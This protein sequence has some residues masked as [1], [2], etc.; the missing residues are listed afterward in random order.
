MFIIQIKKG[1]RIM[2]SPY[3]TLFAF[4]ALL[5]L[6][7]LACY[8][9]GTPP[10]ATQAPA[11]EPPTV[12][13]PQ[14]TDASQSTEPPAATETP[15]QSNAK[16]FF[17]E[18][19]DGDISNWTYFT[20]KNDPKADDSGVKPVTDNSFLV[21]DLTKNLN[22][23]VMYDP[24]TYTNVRLDVRVENRGT[25]N[26][27]INLVCRY[28]KEGWYE[29]AIANNGLYWLL[30]YDGVKGT[31]AQLANGGSNKI[32]AG[33]EVNEYTFICND[34]NLIVKIN[35][36]D[37]TTYTD[38]QY[39]FREGQIG[40]GASSFKDIPVKVEYDWVKISEP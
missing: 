6:V 33:K 23:Y 8:G 2:K 13:Q 40:V 27:N 21:L 3:R 5:L 16:D 18:E 35:G 20:S 11:T 17:T 25:N 31:Y 19:F 1:E 29:I 38:N 37:T 24:Y 12:S 4:A 10:V 14:P 15:A 32:K 22:V 28:S 26:N 30:A 34:R 36:F 7:S 39:V 9:G